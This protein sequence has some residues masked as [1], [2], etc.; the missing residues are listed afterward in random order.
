MSFLSRRV[1]EPIR[2]WAQPVQQWC[3]RPLEGE[4]WMTK[5]LL[6]AGTSLVGISTTILVTVPVFEM[7]YGRATRKIQSDT[8]EVIT[9]DDRLKRNNQLV[10]KTMGLFTASGLY[11]VNAKLAWSEHAVSRCRYGWNKSIGIF[12]LLGSF[13]CM[14]PARSSWKKIER[15]VVVMS[16]EKNPSKR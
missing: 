16:R 12:S 6:V 8:T 3:N 10:A 7:Y 4:Q 1:V 5:A 15:D 11:L 13:T 14:G 2:R 9:T